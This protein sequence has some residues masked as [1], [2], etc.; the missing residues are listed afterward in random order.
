MDIATFLLRKESS[1]QNIINEAKQKYS[2]AE[3]DVLVAVGSLADGLGNIKSDLDLLLIK[4]DVQAEIP[5]KSI[6]WKSGNCLVDMEVVSI[7]T[8]QQLSEKL[9][10]WDALEWDSTYESEL[11]IN[12]RK[13]LHRILCGIYLDDDELKKSKVIKFTKKQLSKLK[14]HA[15]RHLARTIQVDMAGYKFSNDVKSLVYASHELLGCAVD[16]ILAAE[17]YTNPT[18]KWRSRL[19]ELLPSY[20]IDFINQ[21][22]FTSIADAIWNAHH[23]PELNEKAVHNK[24]NEISVLCRQLFFISECKILYPDLIV[25]FPEKNKTSAFKPLGFQLELDVDFQIAL[26]GVYV[27]RLNEFGSVVKFDLNEI[28]V[29]FNINNLFKV[30]EQY[31]HNESSGFT[32]RLLQKCK[33][34]SFLEAGFPA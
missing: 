21:A 9:V 34:S 14:F 16:A 5:G 3:N 13:F 17:E 27:A 29:L 28:E 20:Y 22:N 1:V 18:P 7:A 32:E 2:F 12:E 6:A 26:D 8:V 23:L 15:A 19:L 24:I 25:K 4:D 11:K 10:N 31:R 30:N 33:E